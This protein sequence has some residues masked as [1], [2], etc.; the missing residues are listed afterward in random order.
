MR[1]IILF[2]NFLFLCIS[3]FA[4]TDEDIRNY[5]K[6]GVYA[7]KESDW[8][9]AI[10]C[11][12]QAKEGL[13]KLKKTDGQ[14]YII[15][16]YK[17]AVCYSSVEDYTKTKDYIGIGSKV[18]EIIKE[19]DPQFVVFSSNLADC[20]S[21]IGNYSRAI[22]IDKKAL[23]IYK[24]INGETH[25]DYIT[26]LRNI[27]RFYYRKGDY[28]K[29]IELYIKE[30][31]LLK[32][33]NGENTTDF[34]GAL[35]RLANCYSEIGDYPKAIDYCTKALEINRSVL[36][37]N[38][39][40][41]ADNLSYLTSFYNYINDYPKAIEYGT[42]ALEISKSLH[43][44]NHADYVTSLNNLAYSY[45]GVENYTKAIELG[46]KALEIE[47]I[48]GGEGYS[49]AT[50]LNNLALYNS[51]EG[52]NMKA[53]DLCS[54]ALEICRSS[55]GE[56][57]SEYSTILGNLAL[58]YSYLGD[59]YKAKEI[60]IKALEIRKK[61]TG[62]NHPQYMALLRFVGICNIL[63]GD[64]TNALKYITSSLS[65]SH[66][67]ILHFFSSLSSHQ[68]SSY[69]GGV[70]YLFSDL[71][72]SVSYHSISPN[73]SELYNKS[74]LFAKGIL[75]TTG[76]EINRLIKE[77]GDAESINLLE[78]YISL[79][80]KLQKLYEMPIK[81]RK[82][83]TDSLNQA[84][85]NLERS[86]IER[87]KEYGDFTKKMRTT[88]K[89]V[90]NTLDDDDIA[91]E[92]LSFD[93]FGTDSTIIAALT[94]KKEDSEPKFFPLFEI[95]ELQAISDSERI[96]ST[97]LTNLVWKPLL[98]ELG[99]V[100]RIYFSP[101]G[102]LHKIGIEY[103]PG[104]EDFEIYRL[105]STRKLGEM[106]SNIFQ[107]TP[108]LLNATLYG[109]IDYEMQKK[110]SLNIPSVNQVNDDLSVELS[111][112][113]H[114]AFID[115]LYLRG[116]K[117]SY[118]PGTLE[119]VQNIK[120]TFDKKQYQVVLLSGAEATETTIK[121]LSGRAPLILHIATHG[122]YF[123]ESKAKK[124]E[125]YRFLLNNE[126]TKGYFEDKS[127]TRSGI[128]FAGATLTLKGKDVSMEEDDGILT[129]QEISQLD[130]RGI[131]LVV[132]SACETAKGDIMQ[133]EG[134]FGLQRGFK[135][136]GVKS[137]LMS[138]WKVSDVSTN[139]LMSEF[140]I[141]LCSGKSKRES[142]R[143]AQKKVREFKDEDGSYIFQDPYYWAGFIMLD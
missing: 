100:R 98:G 133:G 29:T 123:T 24:S 70:S 38:H 40:D 118:L 96:Y 31:N 105:S 126:N 131:D 7:E 56:V 53:I 5:I 97:K 136:A 94:L 55:R 44:E 71:Y 143:L 39:A 101:A 142:L 129:A 66:T 79:K 20:Y 83:N 135:K 110:S 27:S 130:L 115:S 127:L 47:K 23:E 74:A 120:N 128:L 93:L 46:T 26:M 99:N 76:L 1:R 121:T 64:N 77:S 63:L 65:L 73:T 117:I 4:Q 95:S 69:W 82:Q 52:N 15:V 28:P 139:I 107:N 92:F 104:M 106:K 112:A 72:P 119:E 50:Y 60:G 81:E 49:Y 67:N 33:A 108:K 58:Y 90:Q 10:I 34:A 88:W 137:I 84:A 134:V 17:L 80:T 89:E 116:L 41:Y 68:R 86:L 8:K 45:F 78:E 62:E 124:E 25:P 21:N 102:I 19:D 51:F 30:L 6:N 103:A 138:L 9:N 141:N 2:F 18:L 11:F 91:I 12:E 48:I 35:I 57:S 75:L 140:Y 3:L 36:G 114:R 43:G 61:V 109:G 87:S 122:F 85:D 13:E 14:L 16:T 111:I 32:R 54:K 125:R 59:Y 22:E 132:L 37:E 42:M 113:Q